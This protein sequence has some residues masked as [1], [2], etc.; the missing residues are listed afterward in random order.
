M[1]TGTAARTAAVLQQ[2]IHRQRPAAHGLDREVRARKVG[3]AAGEPIAEENV[4]GLRHAGDEELVLQ[5]EAR[6]GLVVGERHRGHG[7]RLAAHQHAA[8]TQRR[9]PVRLV[10]DIELRLAEPEAQHRPGGI[11]CAVVGL[12]SQIDQQVVVGL[13]VGLRG[14]IPDTSVVQ[15]VAVRKR[16]V[17]PAG[18]GSL[19]T[20]MGH[21]AA[22]RIPGEVTSHLRAQSCVDSASFW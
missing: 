21:T 22:V 20:R 13:K 15:P 14:D 10:T 11:L 19:D 9:E 1:Q 3:I 16:D 5:P 18:G 6:Q 4:I 7:G 17:R 2:P 12:S 8:V